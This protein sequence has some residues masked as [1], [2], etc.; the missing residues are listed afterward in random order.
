MVKLFAFRS[1]GGSTEPAEP[2]PDAP[3]SFSDKFK[4]LIKVPKT[5]NGSKRS[6]KSC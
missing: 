4:G 5:S 6:C 2:H 3:Q 1:L